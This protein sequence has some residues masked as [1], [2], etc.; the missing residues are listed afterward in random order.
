MTFLGLSDLELMVEG[1]TLNNQVNIVYLLISA[2]TAPRGKKNTARNSAFQ[3]MSNAEQE[4]MGVSIHG[5]IPKW[6]VCNL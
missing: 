4:D 1:V 6:I 2:R 5:D 3:C